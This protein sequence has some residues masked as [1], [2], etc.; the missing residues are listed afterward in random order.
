[1]DWFKVLFKG[2]P[3]QLGTGNQG[4]Y[5]SCWVVVATGSKAV[6]K[7]GAGIPLPAG[8]DGVRAKGW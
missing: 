2:G 7:S 8:R 3:M 5:Q 6:A 4:M 1:M